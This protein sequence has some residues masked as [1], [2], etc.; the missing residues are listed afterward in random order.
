MKW[1]SE[2]ARVCKVKKCYKA[3]NIINSKLLFGTIITTK[4]CN[5]VG[6]K[7]LFLAWRLGVQT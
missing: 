6:L 4:A 3:L 2:T 7:Q 1:K 5:Q